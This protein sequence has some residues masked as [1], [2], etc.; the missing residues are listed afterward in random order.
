MSEELPQEMIDRIIARASETAQT[1]LPTAESIARLEA[2]IANESDYDK[3]LEL[4]QKLFTERNTF[5]RMIG[6]SK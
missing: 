5:Q 4:E 2:E 1:P 6:E 3:A